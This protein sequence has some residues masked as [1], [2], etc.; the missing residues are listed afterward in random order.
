MELRKLRKAAK[1]Y[2]LERIFE[3]KPAPAG[4][5]LNGRNA[6]YKRWPTAIAIATNFN[7]K[8]RIVWLINFPQKKS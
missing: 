5:A 7:L 6:L 8:S 3:T 1:Q 2:M 4:F